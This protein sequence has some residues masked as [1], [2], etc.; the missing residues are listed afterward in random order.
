MQS[1]RSTIYLALGANLGNRRE[2]LAKALDRLR[3]GGKLRVRAVS[4]LYQT[5]PVGYADQPDFLNM[6][7][8][9]ETELEP[10]P[11]LTALKQIE[12]DMGRERTFLNGPRPIDVDIIFY[13]DLIFEN[14]RLQIPHPRLRGR[15]FVLAP[16][17]EL[18]P[19]Y[20]H[21]GYG[22]TVEDL[23]TELNLEQEGVKHYTDEPPLELP[24][25]RFLF[26]TGQLAA[27]WL[28]EYLAEYGPKLGFEYQV[29]ALE[30]E[31][32]AFMTTRYI[33]D[34][35]KLTDE[36]RATLDLIIVPGFAK[37]DLTQLEATFGIRA[38]LGPTD[39][40]ELEAWLERR[41]GVEEHHH[42]YTEAQLRGMQARLTD[43]NIRIYTDGQKIYAFNNML[44]ALGGPDEREIRAIFR[45]LKI[46]NAS[47]AFYLGK[48]LY[49]A[50]LSVRLGKAYHQDRELDW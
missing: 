11:L 18:A 17:A 8:T 34:H 41:V 46:D 29:A 1:K 14:E 7:V 49:K 21:P 9:A 15:G 35:L 27:P 30:I 44:F 38:E 20:L 24:L 4:G 22:L 42:F 36:Q 32:A 31:V 5:R 12:A 39:L 2:N 33:T 48:E 6:V 25:P 26:V 10:L 3:L 19:G 43:P 45:Q 16:L 50:A 28:D 13:D 47:H 40:A 37:G 23:L